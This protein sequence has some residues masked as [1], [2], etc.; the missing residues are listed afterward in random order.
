MIFKKNMTLITN[1]LLKLRSHKKITRSNP[2]KSRFRVS[3]EKQHGECPQTLFTFE[4]EPHLQHLLITGNSTVL[5]KLSV[6]NM[7][8]LKFVS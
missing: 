1:V 5:Q 7:Q 8:I 3:V 2:K 6:S 4:G